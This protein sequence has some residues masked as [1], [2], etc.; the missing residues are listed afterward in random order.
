MKSVIATHNTLYVA[1]TEV[2][3]SVKVH[4]NQGSGG[5]PPCVGEFM[6]HEESKTISSKELCLGPPHW[7][8]HD[9]DSKDDMGKSLL[10]RCWPFV[11]SRFY[12][13]FMFPFLL[14][15]SF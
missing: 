14:G 4:V 5:L 8:V 15:F 13:E 3:I 12:A 7:G 9:M 1:W 2:K 11:H 6:S 10:G